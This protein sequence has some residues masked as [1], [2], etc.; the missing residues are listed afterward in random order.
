M[1]DALR[2]AGFRGRIE[3]EAPLAPYTTWR[4][5]GPAELL[6]TPVDTDDLAVALAWARGDGVPW[7]VLG[8][9]SNLLV[10]D[11]GVRG[12]VVRVRKVLGSVHA[13]DTV[14]HAG[15]G[16]LFPAVANRAAD[17]GVDLSV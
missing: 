14:L 10:R 17:L 7:R 5:G 15:A 8:N 3:T 13:D 16:A 6:A 2:R 12:L 9:G 1:T 11:A 4:I